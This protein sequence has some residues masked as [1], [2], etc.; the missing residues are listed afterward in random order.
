MKIFHVFIIIL[1]TLSF[2]EASENR[3]INDKWKTIIIEGSDK[4]VNFHAW[5][6]DKA[7]A[8]YCC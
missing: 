1:F 4:N 2:S 3:K 5:G 8:S 6:G 7:C